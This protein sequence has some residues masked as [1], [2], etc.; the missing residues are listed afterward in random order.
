MLMKADQA[1][2]ALEWLR[3]Y[4]RD[5]LINDCLA[6]VIV[7]IMLIPQSLAYALLAARFRHKITSAN[8]MAWLQRGSGAALFGLAAFTAALRRA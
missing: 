1:L 4:S 5:S 3:G 8:R 6:A 7:T 2:P